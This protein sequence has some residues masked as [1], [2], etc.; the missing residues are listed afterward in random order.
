MTEIRLTEDALRHMTLFERVTSTSAIDCIDDEDKL[1]FI[2]N[3]KRLGNAIGKGG[4]NIRRLRDLCKRP[5]E[6]VGYSA[7]TEAFIRSIFHKGKIKEVS[8][9]KRGDKICAVV[10][11]D[12]RDKGKLIGK[13]GK[14]LKLARMLLSR[15]S[16]IEDVVID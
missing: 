8:L 7:D 9:E 16:E 6:V 2:V 3:I 4:E 5:V 11:V 13:G 10:K 12:I 14:N 1:V 15:H